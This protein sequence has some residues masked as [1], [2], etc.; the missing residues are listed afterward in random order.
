MKFFPFGTAQQFQT[1]TQDVVS[2]DLPSVLFER[3]INLE[4]LQKEF[5]KILQMPEK[6][7]ERW[8]KKNQFFIQEMLSKVRHESSLMVREFAFNEQSRKSVTT[9]MVA[10]Q[11]T[12]STL[13]KVVYDAKEIKME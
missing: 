3:T 9:Y 10:L 7:K 4:G 11:Q 2:Q 13:E 5:S 12:L 8:I 6:K 1:F